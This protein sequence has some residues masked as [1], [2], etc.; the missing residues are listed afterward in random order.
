MNG[1][2]KAINKIKPPSTP[3]P[4][5]NGGFIFKFLSLK[6]KGP[7]GVFGQNLAVLAFSQLHFKKQVQLLFRRPHG[8]IGARKHP[9]A[10]VG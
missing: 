9:A 10:A 3:L 8:V 2:N 7:F 4:W 6:A 1:K 5:V